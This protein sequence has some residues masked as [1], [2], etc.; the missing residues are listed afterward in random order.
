M[1]K[2]IS[3]LRYV[4]ASVLFVGAL[5]TFAQA[6]P[7][8]L[9]DARNLII[10]TIGA[11]KDT[12]AVVTTDKVVTIERINSNLNGSSHGA[13]NNEAIVIGPI[14]SHAIADKPKFKGVVVIRVQ[15]LRRSSPGSKDEAVDTIEFRKDA[16]GKFQFHET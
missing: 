14:V 3:M 15:Y 2:A 4:V 16:S 10:K 7:T 12:V 13:R 8:A 5:M 11:E 6:Q 1:L 9:D